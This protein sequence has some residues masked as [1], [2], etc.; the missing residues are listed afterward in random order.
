MTREVL[1]LIV[2]DYVA[3]LGD[4]AREAGVPT[5]KITAHIGGICGMGGPHR[6][7]AGRSGAVV[8]GVSLYLEDALHP[9]RLLSDLEASPEA[10]RLPWASP[11]WLAFHP[12]DRSSSASWSSAI[13]STAAYLNNRMVVLANWEG[14]QGI[15]SDPG[16]IAGLRRA[17]TAPPAGFCQVTPTLYLGHSTLRDGSGELIG[18]ELKTSRNPSS[19]ETHL[20]ASTRPD[21]DDR[22]ILAAADVAN[23]RVEPGTSFTLSRLHEGT[24]YVQLVTDGCGGA[25]R[26]QSPVVALELTLGSM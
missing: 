24:I 17:L 7:G 15:A 26:I 1:D 18:V 8:P 12:G 21:L 2:A 23:A 6:V 14:D 3:Y 5:H 10:R 25:K 20:L 16:A 13:E 4:L 19:Q 22:G 11:E 9:G